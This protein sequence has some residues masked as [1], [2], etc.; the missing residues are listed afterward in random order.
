[1]SIAGVAEQAGVSVATVSRVLNGHPNVRPE[2]RDKVLA[3]VATSGYRVNELAR[4]L[5]TADGL[6]M[7]LRQAVPQ[8]QLWFGKKPEITRELRSLL[9]QNLSVPQPQSQE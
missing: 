7:L 1:M 5:R 3:A 4:N 9:E 8:F 6:G 2:T